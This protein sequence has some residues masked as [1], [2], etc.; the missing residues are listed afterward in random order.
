MHKRY[1][2]TSRFLAYHH[3]QAYLLVKGRPP[4]P[5]RPLPDVIDWHY[6]GNR[7]HPTQKSVRILTPLIESFS[8]PS[9]LVLDPFCGSGSTLAAARRCGRD[10]LGIELDSTHYRTARQRLTPQS[11]RPSIASFPGSR[12]SGSLVFHKRPS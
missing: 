10:F 2:S 8:P 4:P 6:T 11:A 12:R 3:E 9:G 7:L 5:L 1:A